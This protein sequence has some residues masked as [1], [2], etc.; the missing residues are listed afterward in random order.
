MYLVESGDFPDGASSKEPT[1]QCRRH[2]RGM[3]SPWVGR[4]P[5]RRA[6]QP[7]QYSWLENPVNREGWWTTVHR[8]AKS[9]A[10]L[11]WLSSSQ[12]RTQFQWQKSD[13]RWLKQ[14]R[15]FWLTEWESSRSHLDLGTASSGVSNDVTRTQC[16]FLAVYFSPVTAILASLWKRHYWLTVIM[17]MPLH[18]RQQN[19]TGSRQRARPSHTSAGQLTPPGLSHPSHVSWVR[20]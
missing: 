18:R 5:W 2:K 1:C 15:Y 3:F 12:I 9:S 8:V 11:K 6:W 10:W 14:K 16:I 13:L 4:I 17:R 7:I 19:I 20:F